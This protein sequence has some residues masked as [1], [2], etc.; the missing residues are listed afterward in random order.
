MST[1]SRSVSSESA[2]V[3]SVVASTSSQPVSSE[4]ASHRMPAQVFEGHENWVDCVCFYPDESKLV[5]G[6]FDGT[7]RIWDR[8]TDTIEV[9]EGHTDVVWDADVSQDGK[10]VISGSADGTVRIWNGESGETMHV[11]E[12]HKNWVRSV[13]FSR[14]STRVVSGSGDGTARVWSVETG[15]LAFEPIECHGWVHCVRYSPGGD[16]IASGGQNVQIW[17][18]DTG[19]GI[20]SI[21]NSYVTSLVW[22]AD[23]T[24]VIGGGQGNVTIWNLH[25]GDQLHT[26]KAH[27]DTRKINTL[28]LSLTGTTHLATSY[29]GEKRVFVFDISTGEQVAAF[30]HSRTSKGIAYS[31][32]GKFIATG[33]DDNKVYLWETPAF[34]DPQ[35]KAQKSRPPSFSWFLDRPAIPLA[36]PSR[37]DGTGVDR[38]WDSLP[39][40]DQQALP[41]PRRIFNKV[42]SAFTDLFTN[43]SAGAAQTSPVRETTEPV[44]VAAG[45][46][47]VFWVV[48]ERIVWTP[49]NTVIFT[50]FY[51]RT[52][53]PAERRGFAPINRGTNANSS[54]AATGNSA[55]IH[56]QERPETAHGT[57]NVGPGVG[58]DSSSAQGR[59]SVI[60]T[61]PER[62]AATS[63]SSAE[64]RGAG[65][66]SSPI[67]SET[68]EMVT[69]GWS[70][71][72][73]TIPHDSTVPAHAYLG[74]QPTPSTDPLSPAVT[75]YDAS[76]STAVTPAP[77]SASSNVVPPASVQ[78][79]SHNADFPVPVAVLV[80]AEE[81]AMLQEF[82]RHKAIP[83]Y[84]SGPGHHREP[85][86]Y[87]YISISLSESRGSVSPNTSAIQPP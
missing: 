81:L 40:R 79:S 45:R 83:E 11:L 77:L 44:E 12:G 54:Q 48:I 30:K 53:G 5:S 42:K 15:E 10:M 47:K 61:Q 43:R 36:G 66:D 6:S 87:P 62:T 59:N 26:W 28:S 71:I 24:R 33:C 65:L 7:L 25:S 35:T 49:L 4:N 38:F 32:S 68:I 76:S 84:L 2:N 19:S 57:G 34:E 52:P 46:D 29:W 56:R 37:N 80:S 27:D 60:R 14:D 1:S 23:G 55:T 58:P 63:L 3:P 86:T 70:S 73:S 78:S 31:P 22:T 64:T 41:P 51:C 39:N 17:N 82:R 74:P 67:P 85:F 16:R 20:L 9:L 21:R 50:I 8:K 72:T 75:P 13:E 69:R 18:A